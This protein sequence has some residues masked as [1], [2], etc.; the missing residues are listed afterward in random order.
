M[1]KI[2]L[3]RLSSL[4]DIIFNIPLANVLKRAGY[5]LHWLVSEKGRDILEGNPCVDK[6]I[7]ARGYFETL[8]QLR[9]EKYDIAIDT[10]GLLKSAVFTAFCGAKRRIT[11]TDAREGAGFAGTERVEIPKNI[12][13]KDHISKKYLKYAQYLGLDIE[14][15]PVTLPEP[16]SPASLPLG[17]RSDK[18]LAVLCPAT[19]WANKHWDK[20][21]WKMLAAALGEKYNIVFTGTA[22]DNDLINYIGNGLNLAGKTNL[23]ELAAIFK[24]ADV[25]ISL[26]SG[27]THLAWA[28]GAQK[29]IAI[30]CA[31]P[32][33]LYTPPGHV[34]LSGDLLCQPCHKK[35]CRH[36]QCTHYPRPEEVI[37][38]C[39]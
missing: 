32:K 11:G 16:S 28:A 31:T 19:T 39:K 1:K 15:A 12:N 38:L 8:W 26:D 30:F 20:D 2:L 13:F 35:K 7:Y 22:A 3:I 10:Q 5:E 14:N 27:S 25:V 24:A 34:G 37:E 29:I 6:I 4:G 23:N 9:A 18:P 36:A 21:H 17:K 33:V